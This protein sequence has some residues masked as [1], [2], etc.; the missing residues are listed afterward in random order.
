MNNKFLKS[1]AAKMEAELGRRV[2][3]AEAE[4]EVTRIIL[5]VA[6]NIAPAFKFGYHTR[7][8]MI[9]TATVFAL[10]KLE[11]GSYDINRPL[12][13]FLY[14]HL[15]N[16]LSNF[17]RDNFTRTER[18]CKC[19]DPF[20]PPAEP[21]KKW[22]AWNNN[23]IKKQNVMQPIDVTVV[24]DEH[25]KTMR[26]YSTVE[27]DATTNELMALIDEKLPVELRG[28]YLKL[29]GGVSIPK[30]RKDRVRE[31]ITEILDYER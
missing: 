12:A 8:D 26:E 24:A 20:N 11:D 29:R 18:P 1:Y 21:C 14:I 22:T 27:E 31:A 13:G 15:R 28:D 4:Q 23:N 19:C 10:H 5:E 6:R 3:V 16:R 2:T 7:G 17:K 25:E 30:V 9:Q